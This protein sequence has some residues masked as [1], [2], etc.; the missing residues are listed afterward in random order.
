MK[1][2][3]N[4]NY[5]YLVL[6]HM[7]FSHIRTLLNY[8]IDELSDNESILIF[9]PERFNKP[10]FVKCDLKSINSLIYDKY[11]LSGDNSY[12]E[13]FDINYQEHV[14]QY[15]KENYNLLSPFKQIKYLDNQKHNVV[16]NA[17]MHNKQLTDMN[18]INFDVNIYDIIHYHLNQNLMYIDESLLNNNFYQYIIYTDENNK[19]HIVYNLCPHMKCSLLFN[20]IEKTWD[21]PCHGSRYDINGKVLDNPANRDITHNF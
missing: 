20:E 11:N 5:L 7:E 18:D 13:T 1:R 4:D 19:E 6:S 12:I 3:I 8:D 10:L 9:Y 17:Y 15:F 21:C 2:E 14:F 16:F